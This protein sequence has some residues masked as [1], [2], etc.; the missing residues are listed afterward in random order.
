[1]TLLKLDAGKCLIA[2]YYLPLP[3]QEKPIRNANGS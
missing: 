2:G 3:N 1:M